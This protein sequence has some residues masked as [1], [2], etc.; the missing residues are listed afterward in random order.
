[1]AVDASTLES[2]SG[3][4]VVLHVVK[5]DGMVELNGKVEGASE[6]GVAFKETGKREVLLYE[7]HQIEEIQLAP[8]AP[9]KLRQKKLKP[10]EDDRVRQHLVD[11]HGV[12]L[13][14]ANSA[15]DEDAKAY[16][17]T[18]DHSDLGHVHV[19]ESESDEDSE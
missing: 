11:R 2:F 14:W 3:K 18:L 5:D 1:M 7:P 17:D 4:K 8:S 13:E 15:S 6:I 19:E 16:H 10:I 12:S 9:K